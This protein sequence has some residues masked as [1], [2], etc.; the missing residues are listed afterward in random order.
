MDNLENREISRNIPTY[1]PWFHI[2]DLVLDVFV[3][4]LTYEECQGYYS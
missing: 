2:T 3:V 1:I 4:S